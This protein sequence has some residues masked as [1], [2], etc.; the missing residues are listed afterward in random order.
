MTETRQNLAEADGRAVAHRPDAEITKGWTSYRPASLLDTL[1]DR[2]VT[3]PSSR[4]HKHV[5]RLRRRNPEA[6]PAEIIRILEKEYLKVIATAGG[7][8]APASSVRPT[9]QTR[10]I[11]RCASMSVF[12]RV[13]SSSDERSISKRSVRTG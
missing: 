10:S 12:A 4:I 6:S 9:V 5:D 2:A 11:E 13:S 8:S 7:T 1:V 3:I